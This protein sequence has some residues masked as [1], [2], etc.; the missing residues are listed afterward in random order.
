[1]TICTEVTAR[2]V[3][4]VVVVG[5]CLDIPHTV[6]TTE[7]GRQLLPR[8]VTEDVVSL[9]YHFDLQNTTLDAN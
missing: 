8:L 6:D 1:M 4:S 2:Q 5:V 9:F 3:Y 7:Q